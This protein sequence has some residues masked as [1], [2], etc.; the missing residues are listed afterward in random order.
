MNRMLISVF[1]LLFF[2]SLS[3][4]QEMMHQKKGSESG[5]EQ[6][7]MHKKEMMGMEGDMME[8]EINTLI[9]TAKTPEDHMKLAKYYEKQAAKMEMKSQRMASMAD[10]YNKRSKPL[11]GLAN[12]C[13][14]LSTKY[15]EAAGEYKAMAKEERE[16]AN[17]MQGE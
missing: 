16:M 8:Q 2:A 12:H 3:L 9:E 15:K 4:A 13:L 14:N 5:M 7:M 11:P 6:K 17:E 1:T 10:L